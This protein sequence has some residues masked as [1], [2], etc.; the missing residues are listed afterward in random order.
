MN[1]YLTGQLP[2]FETVTFANL[3]PFFHLYT[4]THSCNAYTQSAWCMLYMVFDPITCL[5]SYFP[6]SINYEPI[7]DPSL[8]ALALVKKYNGKVIC[9]LIQKLNKIKLSVQ[10]VSK[11]LTC[12]SSHFTVLPKA[13]PEETY[14]LLEQG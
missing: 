7:C 12:S 3:I 11:S 14:F 9:H 5:I 10:K 4:F 6:G 1:L 8:W 13:N 2:L